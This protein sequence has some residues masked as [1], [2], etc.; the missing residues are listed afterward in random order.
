MVNH[1][2]PYPDIWR[3]PAGSTAWT[4]LGLTPDR[5]ATLTVHSNV[6]Y[7]IGQQDAGRSRLIHEFAAIAADPG[8]PA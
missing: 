4:N 8:G 3:A 2:Q 5:S 6:A 1:R 7:A